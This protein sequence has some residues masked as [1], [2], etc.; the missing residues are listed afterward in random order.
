MTAVENT[1]SIT[2]GY[3]IYPNPAS[4]VLNFT[5]KPTDTGNLNFRLYD[6]TGVLIQDKLI[7]SD[8]TEI[9]LQ[10]LPPGFYFLAVP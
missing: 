5:V 10:F 9:N 7:E 8:L 3:K 1:E 6:L 2:L 4:G